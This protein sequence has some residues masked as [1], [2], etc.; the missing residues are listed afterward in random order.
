MVKPRTSEL[1]TFSFAKPS[2]TLAVTFKQS[3]P[4]I[5][6]YVRLK[7]HTGLRRTD[8]LGLTKSH[9]TP[10]YLTVTLSKTRT[11]TEKVLKFEMTPELREVI[12]ECNAIL[13]LSPY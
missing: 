13:P 9:V 1:P 4:L 12:V 7:L 5:R 3:L 8:L 11:S 10:D 6:V 2:F